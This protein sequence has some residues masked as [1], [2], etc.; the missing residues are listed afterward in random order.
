[1]PDI[2]PVS[3]QDILYCRKPD[4]R[5]QKVIPDA[6]ASQM[7]REQRGKGSGIKAAALCMSERMK[8]RYTSDTS[9]SEQRI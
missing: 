9:V 2:L 1:M 8:E 6:A 7:T 5:E 3:M 4:L